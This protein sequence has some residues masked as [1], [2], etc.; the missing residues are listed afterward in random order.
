MWM[1]MLRSGIGWCKGASYA[2]SDA[3]DISPSSP[4]SMK[5]RQSEN[6]IKRPDGSSE[7]L[8]NIIQFVDQIKR[9]AH[10]LEAT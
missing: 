4:P 8:C 5:F 1:E 10:Y 9:I 3:R 7:A 2:A 6:W